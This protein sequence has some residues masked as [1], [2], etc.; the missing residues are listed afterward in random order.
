VTLAPRTRKLALITHVGASVGWL[1]AVL[2]SLVLAVIGLASHD[3]TLVRAIYLTLQTIGWYVLIPLSLASL[4]TGLVQALGTHWGLLRHY[5]VLVKLLMN[6]FATGVLL[7]YM[8]T[9][10]G[11]AD[12]AR[13]ASPSGA[14]QLGNPSPVLHSAGAVVLLISALMLSVFKPRGLTRYGPDARRPGARPYAAAGQ[15]NPA[16]RGTMQKPLEPR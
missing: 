10:G 13:I 7:L 16:S 3:S 11:L 8:Q 12:A 5:W 6:L 15:M 9:L 14:S 2:S 1:G 4:L